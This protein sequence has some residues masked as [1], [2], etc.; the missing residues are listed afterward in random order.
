MNR[1]RIGHADRDL[2]SADD[3]WI[4]E[5]VEDLRSRGTPVC[6]EVTLHSGS[7]N[8]ILATP[9]CGPASGGHE[10]NRQEKKILE[11]WKKKGLDDDNF[12]V[13]ELI[14]FVERMDI[15]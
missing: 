10:A 2:D 4:R 8:M 7:V 14:D 9:G 15:I 6:V 5:H 11:L 12:N 13:R 3:D 1:I